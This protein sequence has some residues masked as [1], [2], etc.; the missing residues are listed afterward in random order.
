[1]AKAD[2]TFP[3]VCNVFTPVCTTEFIAFAHANDQF[4][5]LNTKLMGLSI[6]SNSSRLAWVNQIRLLTGVH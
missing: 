6:D 4:E 1:M 3:A 5:A 2:H